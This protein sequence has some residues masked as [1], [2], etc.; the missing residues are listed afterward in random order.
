M[1]IITMRPPY[2]ILNQMLEVTKKTLDRYEEILKDL[3]FNELE[4]VFGSTNCC[5]YCEEYI[6]EECPLSPRGKLFGC[7]NHPTYSALSYAITERRVMT[8]KTSPILRDR[9]LIEIKIKHALLD[10]IKFHE[11]LNKQN[12]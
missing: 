8:S 5:F 12:E 10:R 3:D 6:C 2:L 4:D 1:G 9:V 7:T 11:N